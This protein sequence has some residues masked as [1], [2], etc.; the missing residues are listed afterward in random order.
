MEMQVAN[1]RSQMEKSNT[2]AEGLQQNLEDLQ[3]KLTVK[4]SELTDAV[5]E[6]EL[7]RAKITSEILVE[8]PKPMPFERLPLT[9]EEVKGS[10]CYKDLELTNDALKKKV[11]ELSER[12]S[13]AV[14]ELS[15][16]NSRVADRE[17]VLATATSERTALSRAMEQNASLKDQLTRLQDALDIAKKTNKEAEIELAELRSNKSEGIDTVPILG[18]I[19]DSNLQAVPSL[20]SD[21][22]KRRM[23]IELEA[24]RAAASEARLKIA[25]LE[26]KIASTQLESKTSSSENLLK[27]MCELRDLSE[28]QAARIKELEGSESEVSSAKDKALTEANETITRLEAQMVNLQK[29]SDTDV[30]DLKRQVAD[31]RGLSE[32]QA[33]HIVTMETAHIDQ[34]TEREK[35]LNEA[36]LKIADLEGQVERFHE[37]AAQ[38]DYQEKL[39]ADKEKA[40]KEALTRITELE[41]QMKNIPTDT[42]DLE[43]KLAEITALSQ[44]Q[45]EQIVALESFK[46]S[47]SVDNL[48]SLEEARAKI[49]GLEAQIENL[50]R[51]PKPES[52][53]EYVKKMEQ[54]LA[55]LRS[56][57]ERKTHAT[58]TLEG[59]S[60]P[61]NKRDAE[62]IA[63]IQRKDMETSVV[64]QTEFSLVKST[65]ILSQLRNDLAQSKSD[66]A[67]LEERFKQA[68]DRLSASDKEKAHLEGVIAQLEMESS[69]IGEYITMFAHRRQLLLKRAKIRD[70]LL[71][72]LMR[73]R[74]ELRQRLQ[75]LSETA[76]AVIASTS[77]E[78]ED[79]ESAPSMT[80]FEKAL[81]NFLSDLD[82][83]SAVE[84]DFE[85]RD[86]EEEDM[87][88]DPGSSDVRTVRETGQTGSPVFLDDQLRQYVSAV[89]DCPHCE[90]CSGSLLVV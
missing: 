75:S 31:L 85:S 82:T 73:D 16:A 80:D 90:C 41:D 17:M 13:E 60:S 38:D 64:C 61:E 19:A 30:E 72:R 40:L 8:K 63:D 37:S 7:L 14:E 25:E 43:K 56:S 36:K 79:Q 39:I 11:N 66:Y 22:E 27:E 4:E 84:L 45:A 51:L 74:Q 23:E 32:R 10:T 59:A 78:I 71:V 67:Q 29:N 3:R 48:K 20:M 44:R 70:A 9:E 52:E 86:S 5:N 87:D 49:A 47:A 53:S 6:V 12:L 68:V 69:T 57:M 24:E 76:K 34:L 42:S 81:S 65:E 1:L 54:E 35:V 2:K 18:Q 33:Q 83:S 77:Q 89:H 58:A 21:E 88:T 15:L 26:A 50:R 28:R 46:N 62:V 55:E